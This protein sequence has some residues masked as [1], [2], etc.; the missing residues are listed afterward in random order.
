MKNA[1]SHLNKQLIN[2]SEKLQNYG[3][4]LATQLIFIED[5][6]RF[7]NNNADSQQK[8]MSIISEYGGG[9]SQIKES[10]KKTTL[11]IAFSVVLNFL[12]IGGGL[13]LLSTTGRF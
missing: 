12:L 5:M 13:Y 8:L 1:F 2:Y 7:L 4:I 9:I 6:H 10:Q 11:I 3:D